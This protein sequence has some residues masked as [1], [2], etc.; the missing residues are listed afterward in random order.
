[1]RVGFVGLGSQGAAMAQ[2]I[3]RAGF[4]LLLWAR[5]AET[6]LPF[7]DTRAET[8][9]SLE[10]LGARAEI[11]GVCVGNDDDVESVVLAESAGLL[12]GMHPG[13]VIA[14][15]STIHPDTCRRLGAR[16]LAERVELLDA[17]VSGGGDRAL[18]RELAVMVGGERSV[19]E[20]CLPVFES[21]GNTVRHLGGLGAGQ[22]CKIINNVLFAATLELAHQ[23]LLRA[24]A[25]ALDEEAMRE[26]L[27]GSSAQS[28]ALSVA[29]LLDA[30]ETAAGIGNLVK[31]HA[32]FS[33]L[34]RAA[35]IEP[36]ELER[37]AGKAAKTI[38]E[39]LE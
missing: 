8:V 9:S 30:P 5:R 36:G 26:V 25:L 19:Y 22:I 11:V 13:G 29:T 39:A 7:R 33:A 2:M 21:Y 37:V 3:E 20:R 6:L 23:T 15:H 34:A 38:G 27:M 18:R 17:P 31:D 1:M 10:E 28:M 32:L 14:V 12:A 35:E 24:R 4:E 16:A